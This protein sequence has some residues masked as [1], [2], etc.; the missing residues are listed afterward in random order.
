MNNRKKALITVNAYARELYTRQVRRIS[1]E[2]EKRGITVTAARNGGF[3]LTVG[4]DKIPDCDFVVYLDKDKYAARMLE[5]RG[6]RLFNSASAIEVC[7]DKMLTHVAL[8]GIVKMPDTIPGVL[9]YYDD[10]TPSKSYLDYV[11]SRLGY[12][13]VVKLSHG[14]QGGG[15]F[16]ADTRKELD[17]LSERV[18]LYPHLFQKFIKSSSGRDMRVIVIGDEVVGGMMRTSSGDFRSN[19]GLGGKAEKC[20]VPKDIE[21]TALKIQK[22]LGLDYCGIDF[23]I[24][25]EPLV[26]EV[27]SNAFFDAFESATGINVAG[28]YA[29]H[30][31]K[32]VSK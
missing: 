4:D 26:C 25:D 32:T 15:V 23:L 19:I 1:D 3:P 22:T 8:D 5:R 16:K 18:K 9:C 24:G 20:A 27:N 29:E 31:V 17:E 13:V 10:A 7:D 28:M 2:L 12:P 30:I 6:L 14:S 11:E 21:E